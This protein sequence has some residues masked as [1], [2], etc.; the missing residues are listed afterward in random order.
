MAKL[1]KKIWGLN[2]VENI[3]EELVKLSMS[4]RS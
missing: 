2:S 3:D 4:Q 1:L